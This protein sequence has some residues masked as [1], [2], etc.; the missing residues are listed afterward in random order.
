MT[1]M[2]V[3]T[4][5]EHIC[6][7][8]PTASGKSAIALRLAEALNGVIVSLDAF[9]IYRGL[10]IG[11]GKPTLE[12]RQRVPHYLLDVAG[13]LESFSAGDYLRHATAILANDHQASSPHSTRSGPIIWT[14]GTGLYY[15]A[16]RDG[17]SPAPATDQSVRAQVAAMGLD[18]LQARVR[19]VDPA[20][21]AHADLNN[22]RRLQRALGVFLTTGQPL[23]TWQTKRSPPLL[24]INETVQAFSLWPE[25][26]SHREAIEQRINGMLDAGWAEEVRALDELD[27]WINAPSYKAIGYASV[28]DWLHGKI[29]RA[30]CASIIFRQTWQYARR[31]RTWFRARPEA[32]AIPIANPSSCESAEKTAFSILQL[33]SG[34]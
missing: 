3:G 9:Q 27:D 17:L 16:L 5:P 15:S 26:S 23:S 13:P 19:E 7:V 33:L 32:E 11:T 1:P 34:H 2:S 30:D 6:L 31:Q 14:G 21:A 29:N 25:S 8:G 22:P 4:V 10:N 24:P 12:E 20:W 18:E 28:R